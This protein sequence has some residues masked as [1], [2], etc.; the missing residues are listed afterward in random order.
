MEGEFSIAKEPDRNSDRLFVVAN[1]KDGR[2]CPRP[3]LLEIAQ[4][5]VA[6]D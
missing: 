4:K 1:A 2:F 5:V 3:F 6:Q